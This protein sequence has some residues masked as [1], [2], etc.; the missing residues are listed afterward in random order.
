MNKRI[1]NLS[2]PCRF[3]VFINSDDRIKLRIFYEI[4]KQEMRQSKKIRSSHFLGQTKT[5][6]KSRGLILFGQCFCALYMT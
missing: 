5:P 6:G 3:H 4:Q 2:L 1:L